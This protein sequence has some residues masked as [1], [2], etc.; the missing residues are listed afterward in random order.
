MN[1]R[2]FLI[3]ATATAVTLGTLRSKSEANA[4]SQSNADGKLKKGIIFNMLPGS[5]SVEDRFKLAKDVGFE[6]IEASPTDDPAQVKALCDAAEKTGLPIHSVIFGGWQSPLSSPDDNVGKQGVEELKRALQNAKDFGADGLLLVPGVVNEE[7]RYVDCYTRS[8]KR[9]KE[10]IP[11]AEKLK[12]PILIENVWNNFLLSPLEA[13]RY[14]DEFKSKWVQMYFDVGNVIAFGWPQ[15]WI[16][17][18]GPR[19][20]KVHLKDFKKGPREWVNLLEGDVN[21][22]EIKASLGE[23]GYSGYLTAELSGGDEKYLRDLSERMSKIIAGTT[24][25]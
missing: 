4:L 17:T 12:I 8:Q 3:G 11:T 1:R 7:V 23:V 10:V 19:V 15:D 22:P 5:L 18:L 9:I 13:V 24:K 25:A 21:W 2:E 14:I 16:R 6:G 20:K